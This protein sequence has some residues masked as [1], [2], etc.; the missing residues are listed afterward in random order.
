MKTNQKVEWI[1]FVLT[2]GAKTY[3]LQ[4]KM[5]K[6]F[7][8]SVENRKIIF[9]NKCD[10]DLKEKIDELNFFLS[11][12]AN[13]KEQLIHFYNHEFDKNEGQIADDEWYNQ[14]EIYRITIIIGK[15]GKCYADVVMGDS[16][17]E[18][19][20]LDMELGEN[21]VFSMQYDG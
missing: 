4:N 20:L 18:D 19:H 14:L 6:I 10:K 11:Q 16:F 21:K 15:D 7:N 5:L 9:Q 2:E 3:Q 1:D 17:F 8:K 13:F 12:I